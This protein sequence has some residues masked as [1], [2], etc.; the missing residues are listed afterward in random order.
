MT[1]KE[2]RKQE[3][4]AELQKL[5]ETGGDNAPVIKVEDYTT[6]EKVAFFD[7]CHKFAMDYL[8]ETEEK[9]YANEDTRHYMYETL[10][11]VLGNGASDVG[12]QALPM[13]I[14]LILMTPDSNNASVQ[15]VANQIAPAVSIPIRTWT[16]RS[17]WFEDNPYGWEASGSEMIMKQQ[18]KII[19][20]GVMEG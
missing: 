10:F 9:G 13:L 17:C 14:Q 4:L 16:F 15:G 6:E 12:Y 20:A 3:L 5:E 8:K 1:P 19:T 2:K 18:I 7:K 11:E